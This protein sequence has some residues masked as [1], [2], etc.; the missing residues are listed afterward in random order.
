MVAAFL[1][2]SLPSYAPQPRAVNQHAQMYINSG[3][4]GWEVWRMRVDMCVL[5]REC[6]PCPLALPCVGALSFL[7]L[8]RLLV[9]LPAA[10]HDGCLLL[11]APKS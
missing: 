9:S 4:E 5:T 11:P 8:W 6:F 2:L 7:S 10:D 1:P 3:L